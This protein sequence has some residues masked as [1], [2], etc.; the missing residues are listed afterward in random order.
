MRKKR[1]SG[2]AVR[3]STTPARLRVAGAERIPLKRERP[4]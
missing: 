2:K 3:M 4:A 1:E